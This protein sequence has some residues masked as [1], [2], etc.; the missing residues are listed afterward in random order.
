[1]MVI[2]LMTSVSL[3]ESW[4]EYQTLD[5][6]L[7]KLWNDFFFNTPKKTLRNIDKTY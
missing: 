5:S 7:E 2:A 1:M 3:F 6:K 4:T